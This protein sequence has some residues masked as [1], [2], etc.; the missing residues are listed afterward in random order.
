MKNQNMISLSLNG[1]A[2]NAKRLINI[3]KFIVLSVELKGIENLR[4]DLLQ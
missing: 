4:F 1:N 3:I 2:N